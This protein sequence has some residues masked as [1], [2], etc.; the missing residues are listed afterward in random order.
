MKDVFCAANVLRY[1]LQIILFK[2]AIPSYLII[3]VWP[4]LPVCT[5]ARWRPSILKAKQRIK[6]DIPA[7]STKIS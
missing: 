3:N 5:D 2:K 4:A 1:V 6:A 7:L